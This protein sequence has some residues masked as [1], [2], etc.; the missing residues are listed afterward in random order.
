MHL[1]L[2]S[3]ISCLQRKDLVIIEEFCYTSQEVIN[4]AWLYTKCINSL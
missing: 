2:S 4:I 3:L 1:S